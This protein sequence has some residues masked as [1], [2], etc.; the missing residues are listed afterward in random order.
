M[1]P[2]PAPGSI[3]GAGTS[4]V[5]SA[6]DA[7]GRAGRLRLP[8]RRR[9][10]PAPG[11]GR[12]GPCRD[13]RA[14]PFPLHRAG[15]DR[16]PAGGPARLCPQGHRGPDDRRHAGPRR[17]TG[18]PHLRRF[19]RR[20]CLGLCPGG[21]GG[22]GRNRAAPGADPARG[23]GRDG[24]AGQPSRRHRRDLQRR[25]LR[26]DARPVRHPARAGAAD[27][28]RRLRPPPDARPDRAG[29]R[30][31]RSDGR[32]HRRDPDPRRRDRRPA[33]TA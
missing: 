8:A 31:R 4:P 25:R 14:R 2:T 21:R 11:P 30:R 19:N 24:T 10:K 5:R 9:R 27:R 32:R 13:H 23:D 12:P 29:R 33:S 7:I 28:R 26:D 16:G 3:T 15:R 6:R 17:R 22:A 20:L 18:G 1:P